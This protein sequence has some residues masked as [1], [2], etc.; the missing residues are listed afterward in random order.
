MALKG[1]DK[2]IITLLIIKVKYEIL[3]IEI[4]IIKGIKNKQTEDR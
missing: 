4:L 2:R 3:I 1:F